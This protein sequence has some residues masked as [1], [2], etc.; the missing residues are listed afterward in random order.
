MGLLLSKLCHLSLLKLVDV[1]I[2]SAQ[3]IKR[4]LLKFIQHFPSS[5]SRMTF[6]VLY[7]CRVFTH[8]IASILFWVAEIYLCA[9]INFNFCLASRGQPHR[10]F[11]P[12]HFATRQCFATLGYI[13][14]NCRALDQSRSF[15]IPSL[16]I[17]PIQAL[18]QS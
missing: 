16:S 11:H 2:L 14:C 7:F 3:S 4:H 9:P 8:S 17:I 10:F 15:L 1:Q 12:G 5:C 6:Q 13:K 18:G